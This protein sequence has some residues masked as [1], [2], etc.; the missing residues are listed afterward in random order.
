[1]CLPTLQRQNGGFLRFSDH[2]PGQEENQDQRQVALTRD[3]PFHPH[4]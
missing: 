4:R 3:G 2:K 1:M